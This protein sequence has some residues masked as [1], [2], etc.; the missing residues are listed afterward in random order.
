MSLLRLTQF[1]GLVISVVGVLIASPPAVR[2]WL[3]RGRDA[4]RLA[5]TAASR[6]LLKAMW[7]RRKDVTLHVVGVGQ[8]S[9]VGSAFVTAWGTG[10]P[11]A[12]LSLEDRVREL[13]GHLSRVNGEIVALRTQAD[14]DRAAQQQALSAARAALAADI[15]ALQTQLAENEKKTVQT[16]A[17]ALPVAVLGIFIVTFAAGFAAWW[18]PY[19]LLAMTTAVAFTVYMARGAWRASQPQAA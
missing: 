14:K 18:L 2:L 10:G 9:A 17:H 1:I 16:D 4:A 8:S 12:V 13:E 3:H 6:A 5:A 15:A 11:P 19:W 7:W